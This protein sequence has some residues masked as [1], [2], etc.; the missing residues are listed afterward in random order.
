MAHCSVWAAVTLNHLQAHCQPSCSRSRL[1]T[2]ASVTC[3]W[4]GIVLTLFVLNFDL[5]YP[6]LDLIR[7]C[8]DHIRLHISADQSMIS[9]LF[10]HCLWQQSWKLSQCRQSGDSD[11]KV[12]TVTTKWRWWRQSGDCDD[13]VATVKSLIF[14]TL[15][16]KH[17]P[18][19]QILTLL[20]HI[21]TVFVFILGQ[22]SP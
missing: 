10:F 1:V 7:P 6:C 5:I 20:D 8:Y 13:K 3:G 9:H 16:S 14:V 21:L 18:S 17:S 22:I 12:A 15:F 4:V 19:F 2:A 11:D